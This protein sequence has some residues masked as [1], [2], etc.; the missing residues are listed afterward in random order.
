MSDGMGL[1]SGAGEE[2]PAGEG[3]GEALRLRLR[4]EGLGAE[5]LLLA[6]GTRRLDPVRVLYRRM[7]YRRGSV[8]Q[9][10]GSARE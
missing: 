6:R 2:E 3:G 10:W 1:A 5:L 9:G 4:E 7:H 8:N